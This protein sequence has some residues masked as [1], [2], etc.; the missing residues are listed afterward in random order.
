MNTAASGNSEV[1]SHYGIGKIIAAG[2]HLQS[3][4]AA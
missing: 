2:A 4:M 3:H 1:E